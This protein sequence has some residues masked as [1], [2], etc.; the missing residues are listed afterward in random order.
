MLAQNM[1]Q[2]RDER[3]YKSVTK[4][5][6]TLFIL[7]L[8]PKLVY[9]AILI[10]ATC[11]SLAALVKAVPSSDGL[12]LASHSAQVSPCGI[13]G[14]QS[15]TGTGFYPSPSVFPRQYHSTVFTYSLMYHLKDKGLVRG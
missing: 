15:S 7:F 10:T 8:D 9:S 2:V 13:C 11:M 5:T 3:K 4:Q 14:G 12:L 6:I 1:A